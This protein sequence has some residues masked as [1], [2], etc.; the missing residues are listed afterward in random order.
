MSDY[1]REL[2][3]SKHKKMTR[4]AEYLARMFPW[5]RGESWRRRDKKK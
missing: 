4:G 2:M 3:H 5:A 1:W